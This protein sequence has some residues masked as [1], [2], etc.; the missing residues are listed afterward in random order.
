[1]SRYPC[2]NASFCALS[3]EMPREG[4]VS[5]YL[6]NHIFLKEMLP[7]GGLFFLTVWGRALVY[8]MTCSDEWVK[9][10]TV[11]YNRLPLCF[12]YSIYN[13]LLTFLY[14]IG[15]YCYKGEEEYM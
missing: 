2:E 1:M 13:H 6:P 7:A 10:K 15:K 8:Q 14:H 5:C 11:D 3:L 4:E 12:I 9:P